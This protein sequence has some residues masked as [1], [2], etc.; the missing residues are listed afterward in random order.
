[1]GRYTLVADG[2][3]PIAIELSAGEAREVQLTARQPPIVRGWVRSAGAPV[4]GVSVTGLRVE[5]V[6]DGRSPYAQSTWTDATGRF[7]L[8]L[9][10]AA[11]WRIQAA[12]AYSHWTSQPIT[13]AWGESTE[14]TIEIPD[15]RWILNVVDSLGNPIRNA[16][17]RVID[18]PWPVH[19]PI[20]TDDNGLAT[21]EGLPPGRHALVLSDPPVAARAPATI[22]L[23]PDHPSESPALRLV[24]P[25]LGAISGHVEGEEDRAPR[26]RVRVIRLD[27]PL[28]GEAFRDSY[29][30][31]VVKVICGRYDVAGMEPGRL[32]VL[33]ESET[34]P[35]ALSAG[36]MG[37]P[38]RIWWPHASRD[39]TLSADEQ[40]TID[41]AP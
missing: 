33:L 28:H 21:I 37:I 19:F 39:I 4:A 5:T 11:T 6:P 40:V 27:D 36:A 18:D 34:G 1:M 12:R 2:C 25:R 24:L 13:L 32:R 29:S 15:T 7:E 17:L 41:F 14:T 20:T 10:Y 9:P 22:D 35:L 31:L 16:T 30:D 3:E 23:P 38:P 26:F 8:A